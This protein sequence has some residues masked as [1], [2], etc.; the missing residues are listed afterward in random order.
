M[1][2]THDFCPVFGVVKDE[3][4]IKHGFK[5]LMIKI[6]SIS[7]FKTILKLYKQ[8]WKCNH[9][10]SSYSCESELVRKNCSISNLTRQSIAKDL[11]EIVSEKSIA[12]R[13]NVSHTTVSNII[14][15]HFDNKKIYKHH[16]PKV[17]CF[18][19]FKSVKKCK[20]NMSFLMVD[21]VERKLFMVL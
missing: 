19:E 6:P 14:Y 3:L 9:C 8:R 7:G 18:D 2:Y 13:N 17:L 21:F 4:I 5:P 16:L 10:S 20:G 1:S 12:A 11:T 15:S